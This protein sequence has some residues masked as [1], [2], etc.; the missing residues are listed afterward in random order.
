MFQNESLELGD[1]VYSPD[2][3]LL[4]HRKE[5]WGN[6]LSVRCLLCK[7]EG[8]SLG[9]QDPHG[10]LSMIMWVPVILVIRAGDRWIPEAHWL[11]SLAESISSVRDSVS[12]KIRWKV[13][14]EDTHT[15]LWH[16]C[17]CAHMYVPTHINTY[18]HVH[19]QYKQ[20]HSR[21]D[22]VRN[23]VGPSPSPSWALCLDI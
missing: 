14:E 12:K 16:P 19:I 22:V 18:E 6:D 7:D 13:S 15:D 2:W 4:F 21:Y 23:S 10:R 5:N 9:P 17:T 1:P 11:M 20:T 3:E 8:L